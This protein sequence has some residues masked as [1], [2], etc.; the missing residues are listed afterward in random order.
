MNTFLRVALL[1]LSL[2]V[3]VACSDSDEQEGYV[4]L[5]IEGLDANNLNDYQTGDTLLV[6]YQFRVHGL[7]DPDVLVDFYLVHGEDENGQEISESHYLAS[8]EF[9]QIANGLHT[10]TIEMTIPP[11][12]IYGKFWIVAYIDPEDQIIEV[13]EEDNHPN[14]NNSRHINGDFP[15]IEID[16]E[17]SAD[18]EFIFVSSYIDGGLVVLDSPAVHEGTGEN[19]SDVIGH[20]DAI[21]HGEAAATADLTVEVLING[22]YEAVNLWDSVSETYVAA[23]SIDFEYN[24]DEHFFGFDIALSDQQLADLYSTYDEEA[25]LNSFTARLTLTDTTEV[26][27]EL[28]HDNNQVEISVPLYFFEQ[29]SDTESDTIAAA[30]FKNKGNRL[31]VDGSYDK[32]YG[33]KKKFRVGVDLAG[34]LKADLIDKAASLEAGGSVDMW[35]FNA[36][37]TIFGIN[38]DGQAYLSGLN[39]GYES[40]M[41]IFNTTVFEDEYWNA[42]FEKTFEKSWEEERILAQAR[43]TVGPVPIKVSAGIDGS[44]GFEFTMGYALSELY[45]GGDIF[46]AGFGGFANGGVDIL[47]VSAGITVDINL[48]DNVLSLDTS[49]SLA[50]L[51]DGV[52]DPQIEYSFELTDEIDIISGRFGLFADVRGVKWCKKWGIPYPCGKKTNRYYLWLYQTPSVFSKNWTL[53][54]KDGSVKL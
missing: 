51:E 11:V 45:S 20:I 52:V 32:G 13:N 27:S 47:F 31:S 15:A 46:A 3:L 12:D 35:I 2:F 50:L 8:A 37:N 36:K 40:E 38:Y 28:S 6:D 34:E 4:N 49:A 30:G 1:L 17:P 48:I 7:E 14:I 9:S 43:F 23:Q 18:H 25:E 39:T 26:G 44:V 5:S 33:D 21:Y 42:K 41:V 16:I 54:S 53:Y 24:G 29:E 22:N 19:H 10:E